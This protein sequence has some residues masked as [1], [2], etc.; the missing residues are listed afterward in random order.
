MMVDEDEDAGGE[1]TEVDVS[2]VFAYKSQR[3]HR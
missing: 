2:Y 1:K 3:G